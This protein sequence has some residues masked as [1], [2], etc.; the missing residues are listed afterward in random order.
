MPDGD[1]AGAGRVISPVRPQP[2]HQQ[3]KRRSSASR[4]QVAIPGRNEFE[5]LSEQFH[6][7][8]AELGELPG[9]ST[10]PIGVAGSTWFG[11]SFPLGGG[12]GG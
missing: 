7:L 10:S 2:P 8:D 11:S 9:T 5:V 1:G 6:A 4:T 3:R 12:H